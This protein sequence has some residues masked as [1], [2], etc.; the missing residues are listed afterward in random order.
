MHKI[1]EP[2]SISYRMSLCIKSHTGRSIFTCNQYTSLQVWNSN[3][4]T[5]WVKPTT[6]LIWILQYCKFYGKNSCYFWD[7]LEQWH[8]RFFNKK[9]QFF[10]LF[11]K[12][13]AHIFWTMPNMLSLFIKN[14]DFFASFHIVN[15]NLIIINLFNNIQDQQYFFTAVPG[16]SSR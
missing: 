12:K 9:H 16:S 6:L 1:Q 2:K 5:L 8:F 4:Y 14:Q 11:S 13:L 3:I 15:N 7:Q 10:H